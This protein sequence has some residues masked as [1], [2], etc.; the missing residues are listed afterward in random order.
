MMNVQDLYNRIGRSNAFADYWFANRWVCW[1]AQKIPYQPNIN[2]DTLTRASSTNPETWGDLSTALAT[3]EKH[4]NQLLGIGLVLNGDGLVCIDLDKC[5]A[6]DGTISADAQRVL[7]IFTHTYAEFSPSGRGI[8]IWAR[9]SQP[10]PADGKRTGNIEIYQSKRYITITY[11][12]LPNHPDQIADCTNELHQLYRELFGDEQMVNGCASPDTDTEQY[13]VPDYDLERGLEM[14]AITDD[15]SDDE[16]LE[17]F[18]ADDENRTLWM[19]GQLPQHPSP[20]E[21]DCALAYR[22]LWLT[23]GDTIRTERLFKLSSRVDR[24]KLRKR[25]ELI[26]RAIQAAYEYYI[27]K[28]PTIQYTTDGDWNLSQVLPSLNPIGSEAYCADVVARFAGDKILFNTKSGEWVCYDEHSGLWKQDPYNAYIHRVIL[29]TLSNHFQLIASTQPNIAKLA[30]KW[31]EQYTKIENVAKVRRQ[32]ETHAELYTDGSEFDQNPLLIPLKNGVWDVERGELLP[33]S[34]DHYFTR[35]LNANYNPDQA[36][37]NWNQ[38]LDNWCWDDELGMPNTE[39]RE[40]LLHALGYTLTGSVREQ[41]LFVIHGPGATGKSTLL[42]IVQHIMGEW[43]GFLEQDVITEQRNQTREYS[44]AVAPLKNRR[45]I[46]HPELA[47]NAKIANEKIKRIVSTEA[48]ALRELYREVEMVKPQHKIWVSTNYVPQVDDPALWRRIVVIPFLSV[49][50]E[51][52]NT[53]YRKQPPDKDLLRKLIAEADGIATQLCQ[54]A[55][56]WYHNGLP[57]CQTVREYTAQQ[58]SESDPFEDWFASCVVPTPNGRV[59]NDEAYKHYRQWVEEQ[60]QRPLGK[61]AWGKRMR[62]KGVQVQRLRVD[63]R[64]KRCVVGISLQ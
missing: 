15:M 14:Y 11:N 40:Y 16:L 46:I 22:L 1:D 51:T 57:E 29:D 44:R 36:T 35:A 10:L 49:F 41:K 37:P 55:T 43:S 64:L 3:V 27:R 34:P 62:A 4:P 18:L 45:Y 9:T 33:H 13:R 61:E 48:I 6:D 8:H 31:R 28:Q 7:D 21:A 30:V 63:G 32:L 38:A 53:L 60:E 59:L 47:E 5:V 50:D 26:T 58:R 25:P 19:G 17:A 39:L 12:R 42:T 20:S 52:A 56:K 54:Y 23:G 2:S 24:E